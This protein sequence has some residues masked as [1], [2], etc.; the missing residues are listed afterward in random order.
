MVGRR[1]IHHFPDPCT[2]CEQDVHGD[3]YVILNDPCFFLEGLAG[4]QIG[5]WC[6]AVPGQREVVHRRCLLPWAESY[7]MLLSM[8]AVL[9]ARRAQGLL[10]APGD[11]EVADDDEAEDDEGEGDENEDEDEIEETAPKAGEYDDFGR[12]RVQRRDEG[13]FDLEL[14]LCHKSLTRLLGLGYTLRQ[15][16]TGELE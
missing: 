8:T 4:N 5:L 1:T 15:I 13:F 9:R 7:W 10:P 14:K 12:L 11:E 16:V 3:D 6:Y 2:Q